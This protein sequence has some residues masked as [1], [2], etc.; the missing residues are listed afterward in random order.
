[1]ARLQRG[2][3]DVDVKVV[4]FGLAKSGTT[5]LFYKLKNSLPPDTTC[6]FEPLFFDS[7][8]VKASEVFSR[9][10]R[11]REPHVLAKVLPFR[12][13]NPADVESFSHFDRQILIVRD[14][15]DRIISRLL[16]GVYDSNFRRDDDK[17]GVFLELLRRKEAEPRS[18][19]LRTLLATFAKLNGESFS[20]DTWADHH[21][22]HSIRK[23]LDFHDA[24]AGLFLFKYEDM[25]DGRFDGLEEY[26]GMPLKGEASVAASLGRV[27]RTKSY[28]NWRD[29]LTEEDSEYLRPLLRPFL[30]RYY[31]EADW[32]LNPSPSIPAEYCSLYVERIVNDRRAS[33]R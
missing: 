12:P 26:L 20:F 16:Y 17:V 2:G 29:W 14:P 28:G 18:V 15:R 27:A 22:Q 32:E 25:I 4:I 6:L 7:R 31:G 8:A 9:L 10:L 33:T 13:N 3:G 23:P 30:E 11:K 19:T 24:R 21:R 5:A 1:V